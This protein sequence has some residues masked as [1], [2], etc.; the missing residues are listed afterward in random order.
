MKSVFLSL[1]CL[2]LGFVQVGCT[3]TG[4]T[5][6]T[7]IVTPADFSREITEDGGAEK[8]T[9]L[10]S[11]DSIEVSVEVDGR[12]EVSSHQAAINFLG[13]ITLPLVGDVK[14]GG[15]TVEKARTVIAKAYGAYFVN[16]PVIMVNRVNDSVVGEWGFVTITGR[17]S[18]P[19]RIKIPSAQG[20]RLTAAINAAGGFGP[21]AKMSDIQ[22]TRI[23]QDGR[24]IGVSINY[25]DIG[26]T[27]N[28][29][30]DVNLFDGDIVYVPQRIF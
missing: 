17:V 13:F 7:T 14:V 9:A 15:M 10:V 5:T 16:P 1:F 29:Q 19:G 21:S 30:A 3:T 25:N 8:S 2:L 18:R 4:M 27:G 26:Q 12:M 23:E 6:G 22:V 24:K 11:G 28:A 20:L